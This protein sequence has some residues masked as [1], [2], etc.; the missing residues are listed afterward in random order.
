MSQ[1]IMPSLVDYAEPIN[2]LGTNVQNLTQVVNP[3]NGSVFTTSGSQI[4]MDLGSR[5]F[6]DTKSIYMSYNMSIT[7][8]ATAGAVVRCPVYA[9]FTRMDLY[10]NS[11]LV[12]SVN[13][14]NILA[15]L[16]TDL[17]LGP[18]EKAGLQT[19]FGYSNTDGA[20]TKYDSKVL[21]ANTANV[22]T[23]SGP[24]LGSMLSNC[25]K[26][27]PAFAVGSVRLVFTLDTLTNYVSFSAN[28][29]TA[30]SLSN[31]QI[32]YDLIDMG[33]AVEQS[34][35]AMDKIVIKSNAFSQSSLV[36]PV[37]TNGGQSFQFNTRYASIRNA[38]ISSSAARTATFVNGKF[39][40]SNIA[41]GNGT[42][43]F[44][45]GLNIG[46]VS[47]PQSGPLSSVNP[48]A[49]LMELRKATSQL[50][51][52]SKASSINNVEFGFSE[53]G[54][55]IGGI[56]ATTSLE[57]AKFFVGIDL[58]KINSSS[59]F[60]LNGVSSQNSPITCLINFGAATTLAKNLNLSLNYD[61]IIT[62]DPR[63]KQLSVLQ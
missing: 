61:A 2:Y 48:A 13:D 44:S 22:Y 5:G 29:P 58:N 24:L 8:A 45:Y 9:P 25:E 37:G 51:D 46:G 43:A 60:A 36:V 62:I 30:F 38:V 31:F 17:I 10:V 49:I 14:Y 57:S 11:Q 50:Y 34:I 20:I 32:T 35:L 54:T 42:A 1:I 4:I 3:I 39:D 28:D 56:T 53:T 52:F 33:P 40:S 23:V 55:S 27:F 21:T 16:Q 6:I 63:T 18:N 7:T 12:E 15:C 47:F 41:N 26:L 59:N 19:A